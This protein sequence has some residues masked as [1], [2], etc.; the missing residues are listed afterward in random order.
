LFL[1]ARIPSVEFVRV[2]K[3]R[4]V[5]FAHGERGFAEV[6]VVD[7]V[8]GV[9]SLAPVE[10]HEVFY[11][12][13][14]DGREFAE[15]LGNVAGAGGEGADGVCAGEFVPAGHARVVWGA[16]ELEDDLRLVDVALAGEDGLA[17]EHLAKDAACAPHVDG[18]SVL[19]QLQEELWWPVPSGND[20]CSVLA[21]GFAIAPASLRHRFVVVARETKICYL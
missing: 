13:E 16:D 1:A 5:F 11:Q 4:N 20:Q 17:L 14:A 2:C 3:V 9:D 7:C 8:D 6:R 18:W 19:P 12:G 15:S 21:L 10:A